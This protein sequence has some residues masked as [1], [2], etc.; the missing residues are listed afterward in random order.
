MRERNRRGGFLLLWA[1]V[2]ATA[3][4]AVSALGRYGV[5]IVAF[6]FLYA[7]LATSWNWMRYA[8]L[9]SLGQAAFFGAGALTQAW[10]V[11]TGRISPWLA[12]GLS[13]VAGALA[14]LPLIPTLRLGTA[15]LALA[16]LSYAIL[17]KGLAGNL[18]VFRMGFLL[19]A[20]P[21][22]NGAAPPVV[23]ALAA[24]TLAGSVGYEAFLGRPGGRAAAAVRQVPETTL[25]L[26]IDPIGARWR[27]LTLSAAA[28]ALAGALYV[29]LVG[30]VETSVVFSPS[31]S[32]L[33][34]VLGMLGG[35]LHPLG[36]ILGTLALYPL[37]ALILR[38]AF[39]EA[40]TLA[41]GIALIGLLLVRPEGLLKAR[42]RKIP[43]STSLRS[44]PHEPFG[45]TISD[46]TVR[47]NATAVLN[48]VSFVVEPGQILRVL[49]P[50]G[51]GKTSLLLTVAGRLPGARGAILFNGAPPPRGAAARAR[52]GLARTFQTPGPFPEWTVRENVAIAAERAGALEEVDRL[53]EELE[54]TALSDRPAGQLSVGEGKRLELAR[55]LAF[56]PAV[57][58]LDEPLAGLAPEAARRVSGLIERA[59]RQGRAVVWVEHGP[60]AD[61]LASQILVLEGGRTR[62]LG[63]LADWDA[64]RRVRSS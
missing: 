60:M 25:A 28:T 6:G 33:P 39:P 16:T 50:N 5:N 13:A 1:V 55:V 3:G 64:A 29:H 36:G 38:P 26:G 21:G 10:L 22:F 23:A 40:H 9:F 34:L 19:P 4:V 44:S 30:S 27:P 17:L 43:A 8:G 62:F 35:A 7:A 51:A 63:S 54:L 41:Y 56:Q 12:L 42:I 14:A 53:M 20:T 58:L 57:L 24:L 2:L 61:E 18:P 47:R 49:G 15:N 59:R 46:L 32:V 52:R 37:D 31:F 45:L 11:T 48:D